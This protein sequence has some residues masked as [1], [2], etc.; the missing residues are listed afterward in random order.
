MCRVWLEAQGTEAT[1][2]GWSAPELGGSKRTAEI[3]QE[4]SVWILFWL[5][6]LSNLHSDVA[7][8]VKVDETAA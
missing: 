1:F 6:Q 5:I 8:H 7:A 3:G 2:F 4:L